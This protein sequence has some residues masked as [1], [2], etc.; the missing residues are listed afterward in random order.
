[1]NIDIAPRGKASIK[2]YADISML[3]VLLCHA[4]VNQKLVGLLRRE[5]R[6]SFTCELYPRICIAM[7][8]N[9]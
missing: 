6:W 1:M 7:T 3:D 8:D 9:P 5:P 2:R 4:L